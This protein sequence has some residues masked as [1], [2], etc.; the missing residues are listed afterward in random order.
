MRK[1]ARVGVLLIVIGVSFL[2]G[3][4]YR[5]YYSN[6]I[7]GGEIGLGFLSGFAP[8]TWSS[9]PDQPKVVGGYWP[10]QNLKIYFS[11]SPNAALDIYVLN[12]QGIKLWTTEGTLKPIF[13]F[14]NV[15]SS[16]VLTM[17]LPSRGN[18]GILIYNPTNYT[19][20]SGT[21]VFY[22]IYG[23]EYDL[24]YTAIA[25][26]TSGVVLIVASLISSKIRENRS[27]SAE[28]K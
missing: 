26:M 2:V 19:L 18:Y 13:Q 4:I 14:H 3:T 1:T 8:H 12:S 10:P 21:N 23:P 22:E 9:P 7:G 5:E 20:G 25:S 16:D 27:F 28:A 17:Q 15:T 6:G 24:L 11:G